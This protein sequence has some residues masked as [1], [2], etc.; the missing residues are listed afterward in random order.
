MGAQPAVRGYSYGLRLRSQAME[1]RN[2][3]VDRLV[4]IVELL[5]DREFVASGAPEVF[6]PGFTRTDRRRVVG[7]PPTDSHGLLA[8][9]LEIEQLVGDFPRVTVQEVLAVRGRLVAAR[10]LNRLGNRGEFHLVVVSQLDPDV[11]KLERSIF[12]DPEDI[13]L[14]MAEFERL[15]SEIEAAGA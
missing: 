2:A 4:R 12:F 14:A 11:E 9:G 8:A 3:A 15:T 5:N 13:E 7:Q 6:A 1:A 10:L